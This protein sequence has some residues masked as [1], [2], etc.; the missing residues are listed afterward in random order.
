VTFSPVLPG[1]GLA[2]WKLLGRTRPAQEQ[3]FQ[4]SPM[5]QRDVE[6]F[7]KVFSQFRTASDLTEDRRAMR[8]VLGAFGLQDDLNSKAFIRRV[9][10]E[11][12]E[13]RS[14]LANRLSDRRYQAMAQSLQHLSQDLSGPVPD[15]LADKLVANF[16]A[17]SFEVALGEVDQ[18][19]RLAAS[20]QRDLPDL[21]TRHSS[22]Q[23]RWFGILGNPPLRTVLETALGLPK[24]F[25]KLDI[26]QQL[27]RIQVAV[28]RRFGAESVAQLAQPAQLEALTTRFLVMS[29]IREQQAITSPSM[30]ALSLLQ[31]RIRP[32][33]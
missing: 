30:T 5:I 33:R 29:Q 11:G 3:A 1:G 8:V 14:A 25:G 4:R 26:D 20:L 31:S 2:A 23:A 6:H 21:L 18:N 28:R 9:I 10:A 22:D 32:M 13:G 7:R 19:I 16:Q 27:T 17:R 12:V 24:E 15:G